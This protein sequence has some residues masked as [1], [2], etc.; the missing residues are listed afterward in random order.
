M[1]EYVLSLRYKKGKEVKTMKDYYINVFNKAGELEETATF[2][3]GED[4]SLLDALEETLYIVA[5]L[6]PENYKD[7]KRELSTYKFTT[8]TYQMTE[9][10][11]VDYPW[12]GSGVIEVREK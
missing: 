6:T 5:E 11:Y 10:F 1:R 2:H 7:W 9:F 4:E 8:F 12:D 3:V